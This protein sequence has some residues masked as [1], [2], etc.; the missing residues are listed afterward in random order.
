M[1]GAAR[2]GKCERKNLVG[3]LIKPMPDF[4]GGRYKWRPVDTGR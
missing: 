4:D 1:K 3:G 2:Y